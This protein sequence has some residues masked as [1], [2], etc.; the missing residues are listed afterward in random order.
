MFTD[1]LALIKNDEIR[2]FTEL[3]LKSIPVPVWDKPSSSTGKFHPPHSQGH[4]G[5]YRHTQAVVVLSVKLAEVFELN[6]EDTDIVIAASILHDILKYGV[7]PGKWT[8]KTHPEDAAKLIGLIAKKT[9]FNRELTAKLASGVSRHMGRWSQD[10]PS[11]HESFTKIEMIV[12]IADVIAANKRVHIL[13]L[14][15][16]TATLIA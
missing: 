11:F 1:E 4:R 2:Q 13:D 8:T 7:V 16:D 6:P 15:D 5:L 3:V 9:G 14:E 10:K 12:H